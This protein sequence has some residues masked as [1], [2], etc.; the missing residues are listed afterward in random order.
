MNSA[1]EE[2]EKRK[3]EGDRLSHPRGGI[4]KGKTRSYDESVS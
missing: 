2:R 4:K 3:K 1:R